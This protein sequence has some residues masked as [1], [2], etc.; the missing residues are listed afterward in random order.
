MN[1]RWG[2]IV[3]SIIIPVAAIVVGLTN[4]EIKCFFRLDEEACRANYTEVDLIVQ[5]EQFAPLE[6]VQVSFITKG[7]PEVRR[8]DSNGYTRLRVPSRGDVEVI[9]SKKDFETLRQIIN[10]GNDSNRTR[11]YQL[12]KVASSSPPDADPSPK[13]STPEQ[14]SPSPPKN[15]GE[16]EQPK[17]YSESAKLVGIW[18]A[19]EVEFGQPNNFYWQ[20]QSNGTSYFRA[21]QPNG[22]SEGFGSWQYSNG[23]IFES[24]SNGSSARG[25]I[26]WLS[27]NHFELT[28]INNGFPAFT[29]LK[30]NYYRQ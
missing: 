30:R 11:T 6:N 14:I 1:S 20:L 7:A 21:T 17:S 4:K 2:F 8:T 22:I 25:S 12:K 3:A 15:G 28:I 29:G 9:L 26:R 5:T 13:P 18:I 27:D 16:S 19:N 10:L 24:Y 23:V